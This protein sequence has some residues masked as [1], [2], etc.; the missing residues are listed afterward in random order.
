MINCKKNPKSLYT[1]LEDC[2]YV[3]KI[4]KGR[5]VE[6]N[7]LGVVPRRL[8]VCALLQELFAAFFELGIAG[9]SLR[10]NCAARVTVQAGPP[11]RIGCVGHRRTVP[12]AH[13]FKNRQ[14]GSLL[15]IL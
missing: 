8:R 5:P 3:G 14:K 10:G 2:I 13:L 4:L 15:E 9:Q 12:A 6:L 11:R 1:C 7:Q